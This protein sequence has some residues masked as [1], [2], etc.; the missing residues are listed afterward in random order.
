MDSL[1]CCFNNANTNFLNY[2]L[3]T[4]FIYFPYVQTLFLPYACLFFMP[5]IK[6]K[7]YTVMS[8]LWRFKI[9]CHQNR[10]HVDNDDLLYRLTHLN[11]GTHHPAY[12][13][14]HH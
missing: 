8:S 4:F 12:I 6:Q 13:K 11:L 1:W 2:L 14:T 9:F 5:E 10:V 3:S 7:F